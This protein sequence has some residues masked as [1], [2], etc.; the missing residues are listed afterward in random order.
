MKTEQPTH[1]DVKGGDLK[2]RTMQFALRCVKLAESLPKSTSGQTVSRQLTRSGTSVA[3]NYRAACRARSRAEFI[4]KLGIVEEEADES[5]FWIEFA[6]AA[7][8]CKEP[9][10][11]SLLTEANEIVAIV[12]ASKKTARQAARG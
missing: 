7:D 3:A 2:D 8:L 10:V 12:V 6:V 1:I 11:T 5:L 9:L 4:A